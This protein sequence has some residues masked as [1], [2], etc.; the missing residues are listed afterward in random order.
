MSGII[1]GKQELKG[2]INAKQ[3]LIGDMAVKQGV[4]GKD[5]ILTDADKN[6]IAELISGTKANAI[7]NSASGESILTTDSANN[8]LESMKTFGKSWQNTVGGNQLFEKIS[9][10]RIG[11]TVSD[12]G[13]TAKSSANTSPG[14]TNIFSLKYVDIPLVA[15]ITYYVSA[16]MKIVS[17]SVQSVSTPILQDNNGTNIT[18]RTNLKQPTINSEY[19]LYKSSVTPTEDI[20]SG[21]LYIQGQVTTNAIVEITDIMISTVDTEWEEYVGGIP[22]PNPNYPQDIH[23]NGESGSIEYGVYGGNL[24]NP[25][26]I[27][28]S[29]VSVENGVITINTDTTDYYLAGSYGG[30]TSLFNLAKGTYALSSDN[31]NIRIT[32]Y[33]KKDGIITAFDSALESKIT[34]F[35]ENVSI[36]GIRIRSVDGTSLNGKSFGIMLNIGSVRLPFEPYTKQPLILQ[37][38]NGLGGLELINSALTTY[39]DTNGKSYYADT[40]GLN[41]GK[42]V[43]KIIYCGV[44]DFNTVRIPTDTSWYDSEKSYSYELTNPKKRFLSG[45]KGLCT[46]FAPYTFSDFYGKKVETGFMNSVDY[47]VVNVSKS[48][49]IC[50][51]VDE[52]KQWMTDNNVRFLKALAGPIETDLTEEEI[53]QY[54]ALMMNYPNTTIINDA[55]AYTEV[56]YVADTKCYIDNKFKELET[57]LVNVTAEL[58]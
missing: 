40:R 4:D 3:S 47:I 33:Y 5:Y 30:V 21:I 18:T 56:E 20:V 1:N 38:P 49:G 55:N 17:G 22:S 7:I 8:P 15:G 12:N 6:E 54:K 52:F 19:Q 46:H 41:S 27:T 29:S 2:N 58:L 23:S 37:T 42:N 45:V 39:T 32:M 44:N 14:Y 31:S 25:S 34:T 51:T 9:Y 43:Q 35:W 16:K 28:F 24:F 10:D 26:I 50:K 57:K 13:K 53:A 11:G 48:L 36:H